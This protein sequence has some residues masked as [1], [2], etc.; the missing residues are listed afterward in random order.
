MEKDENLQNMI[1]LNYF[2]YAQGLK[3]TWDVKT[4]DWESTKVIQTQ[5]LTIVLDVHES[6]MIHGR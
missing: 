3:M 1:Q 6:R 4:R 2:A 5:E